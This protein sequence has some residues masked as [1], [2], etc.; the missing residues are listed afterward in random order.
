MHPA[1]EAIFSEDFAL[2]VGLWLPAAP[3][4]RHL[5]RQPEALALKEALKSGGLREDELSEHVKTM[6]GQILDG[7]APHLE[8]AL[9]LLAVVL[10][11]RATKVAELFLG[12][13]AALKVVEFR[14]ASAVARECLKHRTQN[15]SERFSYSSEEEPLPSQP[16]V[17]AARPQQQNQ[18]SSLLTRR[19][20]HDA[21]C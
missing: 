3:M 7:E 17:R 19:V 9:G 20:S 10:E 5:L 8:V 4:R 14:Q 18:T 13:L 6:V 16:R 15:R 11:E 2:K 12:E 1:V 21:P